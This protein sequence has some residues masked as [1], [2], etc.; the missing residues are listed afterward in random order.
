[1]NDDIA[2]KLFIMNDVTVEKLF[3]LGADAFLLY[4]FYYKTAKW[5][6]NNE[7]WATNEYVTKK[8]GWGLKKVREIKKILI[9]NGFISQ[10]KQ[11]EN[12]SI[13]AWT[14]RLKYIQNEP[15]RAK[16]PPVAKMT[17]NFENPTPAKTPPVA[18]EPVY[19]YN[20]KISDDGLIVITEK[21][22]TKEKEREKSFLNPDV[23]SFDSKVD[24][25]AVE[26]TASIVSSDSNEILTAVNGFKDAWNKKICTDHDWG[27]RIVLLNESRK[28]SLKVRL[29]EILP[30]RNSFCPEKPLL[31]FFF[32]NVLLVRIS[33]SNFLQG[34]VEPTPNHPN[35]FKLSIDNIISPSFFAKLID[36]VYDNDKNRF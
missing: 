21:E 12:G 25:S 20:N 11:R 36:G 29:K 5:Q 24:T 23:S 2:N 31:D 27:R 32:D 33:K 28:K 30:M 10:E 4:A 3:S 13:T 6:K 15:T 17:E 1:M 14:I 19:I 26:T 22:M 8:L 7:I 34:M 9:D 35:R 16:T 18:K